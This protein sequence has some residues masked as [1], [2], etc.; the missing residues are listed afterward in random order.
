M[1]AI[2]YVRNKILFTLNLSLYYIDPLYCIIC[3][4][5][6]NLESYICAMIIGELRPS[7]LV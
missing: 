2:K 6:K 1:F 3:G 5:I 7:I 4:V